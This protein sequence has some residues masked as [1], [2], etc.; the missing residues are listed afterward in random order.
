[1]GALPRWPAVSCGPT[2]IPTCARVRLR[3]LAVSVRVLVPV[4]VRVLRVRG[5]RLV[6]VVLPVLLFLCC[7][8]SDCRDRSSGGARTP[9]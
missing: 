3:R 9:P 6:R 1:M 7:A 8:S 2:T 5:G 4:L